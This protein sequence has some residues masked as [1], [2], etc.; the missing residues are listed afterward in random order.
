MSWLEPADALDDIR[1]VVDVILGSR[2]PDA[3]IA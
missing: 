2:R 3:S 1:D